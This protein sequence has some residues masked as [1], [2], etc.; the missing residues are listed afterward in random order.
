MTRKNTV[1]P[2]NGHSNSHIEFN[3][4]KPYKEHDLREL[5]IT[6]GGKLDVSTWT[7]IIIR[8]VVKRDLRDMATILMKLAE[9][10][11]E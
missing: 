9:K 10:L 6:V 4:K 1:N 11:P 7:T 5:V 3:V 2:G 8:D